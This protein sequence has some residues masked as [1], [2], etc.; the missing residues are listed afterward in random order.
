[1]AFVRADCVAS[2]H[3]Q[4]PHLLSLHDR[5]KRDQHG[6]NN[7]SGPL[8]HIALHSRRAAVPSKDTARSGGTAA[9]R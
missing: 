7:G 9:K 8:Q 5:G 1:M 6:E 2:L 3:G 4:G